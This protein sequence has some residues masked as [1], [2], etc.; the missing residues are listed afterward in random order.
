MNF[1]N[2]ELAIASI[3]AVGAL[4]TA[5]YGVVEAFGKA[6]V[7]GRLG[8]PYV[9]FNC[10]QALTTQF[11]TALKFVHGDRFLLI[12]SQQYRDG[13]AAGQAPDTIRQAVR[14]A[15]PMMPENEAV[16]VVQGVWG[17]DAADSAA[18]VTAL[19]TDQEASDP[20]AAPMISLAQR[21]SLALDNRVA[22]AFSQAEERYQSYVRVAAGATAILLALVFNAGAKG[23]CVWV[24]GKIACAQPENGW[25]WLVALVIGAAA[26]PLAPIAKDLASS[27]S[28]ALR[29][30]R[31]VGVQP[32]V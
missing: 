15:L 12:L 23:G 29:A 27:L 5:A 30:W 25:P 31:Q 10:V 13:R 28:D 4:G 3:V 26:T 9:G 19:Q 17:M 7:F 8:L 16:A 21:F 1:D 2:M 20:K 22:S 11:E 18:L 32:K 14:L 6:L 24:A